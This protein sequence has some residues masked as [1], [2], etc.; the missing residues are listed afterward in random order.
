MDPDGNMAH[1]IHANKLNRVI[2]AH[3]NLKNGTDLARVF[4][5]YL[6]VNGKS[7][8]PNGEVNG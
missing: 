6:E 5:S 7:E 8:I 2:G 4:N 3:I 1:Q